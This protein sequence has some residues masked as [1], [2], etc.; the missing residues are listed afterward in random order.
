MPVREKL[1]IRLN[2]DSTWVKVRN[3]RYRSAAKRGFAAAGRL[4]IISPATCF[5]LAS[6]SA[7]TKP[8]SSKESLFMDD[9]FAFRVR[10]RKV[11]TAYRREHRSDP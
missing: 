5:G 9:T 11:F 10:Y 3:S 2:G 1:M 8:K 4:Q 7:I 6:D